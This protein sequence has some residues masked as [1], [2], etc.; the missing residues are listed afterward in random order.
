MSAMPGEPS[1]RLLI[2]ITGLALAAG[3]LVLSGLGENDRH[4]EQAREFQTLTGGLGF[5]PALDLARCPY[6]LDPRLG[7]DAPGNAGP[8]V[9]E[10]L[11]C[12]DRG[13]AIF[14]YP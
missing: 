13:E 1:T 10:K 8:M 7:H 12:P 4:T 11:V 6:N 14:Y 5:G 3:G 9:H 2:V